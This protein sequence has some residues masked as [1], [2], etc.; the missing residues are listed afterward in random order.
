MIG[1]GLKNFFVFLGTSI[2]LLFPVSCSSAPKNDENSNGA[3]ST[4]EH[5]INAV[6]ETDSFSTLD[7]FVRFVSAEGIGN[8]RD[9]YVNPIYT[10]CASAEKGK[11]NKATKTRLKGQRRTYNF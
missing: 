9:I 1:K 5:E 6:S 7:S 8:V 2:F 11:R 10:M 3:S 4:E